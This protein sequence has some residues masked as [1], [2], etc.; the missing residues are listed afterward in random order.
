MASDGRTAASATALL[1]AF[2]FQANRV[3]PQN[4]PAISGLPLTNPNHYGPMIERTTVWP[5]EPRA[6]D[7]SVPA[8]PLLD[9]YDVKDG[10]P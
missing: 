10:F 4:A 3:Q 6:S 9:R 1:T 2:P 8:Q 5:D 7:G